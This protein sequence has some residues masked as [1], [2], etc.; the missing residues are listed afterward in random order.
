MK[1]ATADVP[2]SENE[3]FLK[4]CRDL[5]S[6]VYVRQAIKEKLLKIVSINA[7]D[8]AVVVNTAEE[9]MPDADNWSSGGSSAG[10]ASPKDDWSDAES[11]SSSSSS[12]SLSS[13]SEPTH[14][15]QNAELT[16]D[17]QA[18]TTGDS[19]LEIMLDGFEDGVK[20]E[21]NW[22]VEALVARKGDLA[23]LAFHWTNVENFAGLRRPDPIPAH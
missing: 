18:K 16:E 10:S 11:D 6:T 3:Q 17:Q 13:P 20:R 8:E 2:H 21:E 19:V 4:A 14:G 22:S 5:A 12:S 15:C 7:M 1:Q 23:K 9:E